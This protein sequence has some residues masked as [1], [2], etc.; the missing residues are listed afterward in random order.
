M[1]FFY[2]NN[3]TEQTIFECMLLD[4]EISNYIQKYLKVSDA[5]VLIHKVSFS[6]T[7]CWWTKP[8]NGRFCKRLQ[9]Q[10]RRQHLLEFCIK[11]WCNTNQ[12]SK[13]IIF[14]YLTGESH[15]GVSMRFVDYRFLKPAN[16]ECSIRIRHKNIM[17][18]KVRSCLADIIRINF[19][20]GG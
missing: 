16:V 18:W 3:I 7:I 13:A 11:M 19:H 6:T 9:V 20:V 14:Y 8:K 10:N 4:I 2:F 12:S 1:K 5:S 15:D 17:L